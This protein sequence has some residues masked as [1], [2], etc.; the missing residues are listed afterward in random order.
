M[1]RAWSPP[2]DVRTRT[3]TTFSVIRARPEHLKAVHDIQ[4]LAYPGL[5]HFHES[6]EV[7]R[8]KMEAYPAGNFIALA[9]TSVMTDDDTLTWGRDELHGHPHAH[10][11]NNNNDDDDMHPE[12]DEP[13]SASKQQRQEEEENDG[14]HGITVVEITETGPDG[15]TTT[16]TSTTQDGGDS[17][18]SIVR[19][20][21]PDILEGDD[22]DDDYP[23][24]G[25]ASNL[26]FGLGP[27][28]HH[29]HHHRHHHQRHQ[30]Q[31]QHAEH[32]ATDRD[33]NDEDH[34][35]HGMTTVLFQWEEPVGYMFSHPYSRES[36]SLHRLGGH[37]TEPDAN[38][39]KKMRLD[40]EGGGEADSDEDE[41][42]LFDHDQLME[43]YYIHDCA[44][45]PNWRGKGLASRLLRALEESLAPPR[46]DAHLTMDQG[47]LVDTEEEDE[48]ES[49]SVQDHMDSSS[50]SPHHHRRRRHRRKGHRGSKGSNRS[51]GAPNLKEIVLV[52]VQGTRPFWE[53][54]GGF[55][56][57]ADHDMDL[58][59]Y[60][61]S[62]FLMTKPFTL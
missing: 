8:S 4:L 22:D 61:D 59:V 11:D 56:V 20:R 50:A 42:D 46:G 45:H 15:T 43:K 29:H 18:I 47:D 55:Q 12:Y 37:T 57:V 53:R 60:G 54:S 3:L 34:D 26:S 33:Q 52:S 30:G 36:V 14:F 40:N 17:H 31:S 51:K 25:G 32:G 27:G 44:I 19:A 35:D 48:G 62:A 7:F 58:S 24:G 49:E 1:S 38:K 9:T 5:P 16:A 10:G 41:D 21:T 23:R 39:A 2:L 28:D 6:P 13:S